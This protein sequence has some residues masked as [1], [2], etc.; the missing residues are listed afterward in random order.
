MVLGVV[1]GEAV[2][3]SASLPPQFLGEK[4][5]TPAFSMGTWLG[6]GRSERVWSRSPEPGL[7]QPQRQPRS[8]RLSL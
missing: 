2:R 3:A 7:E 5:V 4:G 1:R 6:L 8:P